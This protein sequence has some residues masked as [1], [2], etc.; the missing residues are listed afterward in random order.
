MIYDL[1]AAAWQQARGIHAASTSELNK[2]PVID[3]TQPVVRDLKRHE[4]RA[5]L[6]IVNRKS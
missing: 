3:S 2:A 6:A 5:P 4:C 1:R